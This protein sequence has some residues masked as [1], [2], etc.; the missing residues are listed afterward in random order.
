[1]IAAL[2]GVNAK[3]DVPLSNWAMFYLLNGPVST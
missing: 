2:R 1:V 3:G